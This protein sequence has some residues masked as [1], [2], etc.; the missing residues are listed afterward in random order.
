MEFKVWK[1][2]N[3]PLPYFHA[4]KNLKFT[5]PKSSYYRK[6]KWKLEPLRL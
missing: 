5:E 2:A 4:N 3:R 1:T 6:R